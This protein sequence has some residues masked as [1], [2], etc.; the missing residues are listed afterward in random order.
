MGETEKLAQNKS[1]R[2]GHT[3]MGAFIDGCDW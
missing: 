1:A 2:I 3:A